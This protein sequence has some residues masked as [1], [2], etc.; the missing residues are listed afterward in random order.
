MSE[1]ERIWVVDR[2]EGG[3]AVLVADDD[4]ETLDVP[5]SDSGR[6]RNTGWRQPLRQQLFGC[7]G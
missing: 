1:A 4:Q 5:R 6:V 7:H 2:V 3:V